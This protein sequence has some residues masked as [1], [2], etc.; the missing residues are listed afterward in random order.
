MLCHG[1]Y[2]WMTKGSAEKKVSEVNSAGPAIHD[3]MHRTELSFHCYSLRNTTLWSMFQSFRDTEYPFENVNVFN[4]ASPLN[5]RNGWTLPS[6]GEFADSRIHQIKW[7]L[8]LRILF[9]KLNDDNLPQHV[10]H[11][12]D[13]H[14]KVHLSAT[15]MVSYSRPCF[16]HFTVADGDWL[17]SWSIK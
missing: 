11:A 10:G 13:L 7:V 15:I 17:K 9:L 6:N 14:P 1:G 12:S 16:F 5:E 8:P 4:G 2:C 3:A